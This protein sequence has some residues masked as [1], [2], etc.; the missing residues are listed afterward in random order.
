MPTQGQLWSGFLNEP[1]QISSTQPQPQHLAGKR[2]LVTGAGGYL[3]SALARQLAPMAARLVLLDSAEYGLYR[4]ERSLDP[5]L[6]NPP[7]YIVG[8]V[9]NPAL[10]HRI[11]AD[12]APQIVFHAAALK[13]VPL[14]EANALAA[15]ETNILGTQVCLQAAIQAGVER[16]ILLSTDKA[17]TP[18]SVMGATKRV[19]EQLTLAAGFTAVRLPNVLGSTGSVAPLFVKQIW[20]GGPVTVT[21]PE[22][23]RFFVSLQQAT[24]NLLSAN[25]PG[26]FIPHTG[27]ARRVTE[28]AGH[29]IARS[30]R[31]GIAIAY[32]GL[33]PADRLHESLTAP[34]ERVGERAGER[35]GEQ[36]GE[37]IMENTARLLAVESPQPELA[38]LQ[39]AV[40]AIHK[41]V[42]AWDEPPL[43]QILKELE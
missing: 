3:G 19:A 30:G 14:M 36:A 29:M 21:H 10:L 31:S 34:E 25:I 24:A 32:I 8:S 18:V 11:F 28:L 13:H 12:H 7:R 40:Q 20:S 4:L 15:A 26:L 33:R 6:H 41:A 39:K 2:I 22:A 17:V 43:L 42:E 37:P 35:V 16:F 9:S 27:I 5:G 23:T 1:D 38:I